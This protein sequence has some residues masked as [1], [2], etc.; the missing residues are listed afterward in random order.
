MIFVNSMSD[1]FHKDIDHAFIDRVFDV[2]EKANWHVFQ[3][4]TK[5]GSPMRNFVKSRYDGGPLSPISGSAFRL[6][7]PPRPAGSST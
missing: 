4:L 7:T 5:R 6:K 2:M 1:L 3:V